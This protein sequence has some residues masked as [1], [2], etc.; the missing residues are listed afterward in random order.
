MG[1]IGGGSVNGGKDWAW[2]LL[3]HFNPPPEHNMDLIGSAAACSNTKRNP[4]GV[5]TGIPIEASFRDTV[6]SCIVRKCY[7]EEVT[8]H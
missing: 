6:L 1:R 7:W 8:Y 4:I 5:S 2:S 3:P